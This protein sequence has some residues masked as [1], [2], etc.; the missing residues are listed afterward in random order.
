MGK[1]E[2]SDF[3]HPESASFDKLVEA[4]DRAYH[5]PGTMIWRSFLHGIMTA[6]GAAVGWILILIVSGFIF[7]AL[8]GIK[9]L[10]PTM[11]RLRDSL[12]EAQIRSTSARSQEIYDQIESSRKATLP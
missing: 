10:E 12:L 6:I 5:R 8:G 9:I 1:D 3:S 2:F 7:Q 4:L 11:N